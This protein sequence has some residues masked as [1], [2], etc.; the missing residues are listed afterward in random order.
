MGKDSGGGG[1]GAGGGQFSAAN[2]RLMALTDYLPGFVTYHCAMIGLDMSG[3]TTLLYRLKFD[4]YV[5]AAPTIGFN[6]EKIRFNGSSF[7]VWD[8]GGQDKLRPLWRSYTRCT[9]GIIF[10]VDSSREETLE[11]AKLELLNICKVKQGQRSSSTQGQGRQGQPPPVLVLANKQD[12]PSAV[13]LARI[14]RRLGLRELGVKGRTWNLQSTCAVTGEGLDEGMAKLTDMIKPP[15]N[16]S[17][18]S[19]SGASGAL[20]GALSGAN[21]NGAK[22]GAAANSCG[23]SVNLSS[24]GSSASSSSAISQIRTSS[25]GSGSSS[26]S[27]GNSSGVNGAISGATSRSASSSRSFGAR[28]VRRSHSHV[29]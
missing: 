27:N 7:M 20:G 5:S 9:D 26:S 19:S 8:V 3:K 18:N 6:C 1:G 15:K 25:S 29:R 22:S 13:D 24:S 10:V 21:K 28:R 4:Q 14:E 12:L 17:S 23:S 11:E 2:R 16:S